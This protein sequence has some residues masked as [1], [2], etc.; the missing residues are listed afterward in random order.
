ME[1]LRTT[2]QWLMPVEKEKISGERYDIYPTHLLP[3]D[4]IFVGYL[5]LARKIS[6]ENVVIIDG[7][8]GV[9]WDVFRQNLN[10]AL[11]SL[12]VRAVWW[13][14][15][16]ALKTEAEI[17]RMAEPFL[18]GD[19][20][21][22]GKKTGLN[23][24]DYFD[25]AGLKK[26][27]P[28]PEAGV[29]ILIG[30]GAALAGWEGCLI[31]IDVPKNEIQFRAKAGQVT[32]LGVAEPMHPKKMY[33]RFYFVD[34]ILL[35][36]HKKALLPRM[37]VVVDGQHLDTISWISGEDLRAGL[38]QLACNGF[39]VRPWFESATWGGQWIKKHIPGLQTDVPNYA[40]SFELIV[41]E[42]GILF[43]SSSQM[44]EVS[45]DT[46]MFEAGEKVVGSDCYQQYGDEFPIRMD[47]LDNMEGGNLSLQCHPK[48]EYARQHFG[49]LMAQEETYYIL[50][51]KDDA[52]VYLGFQD[53][54]RPEE[55]EKALQDSFRHKAVL[56]VDRY[57]KTLPSQKHGLYLIPPGTLHSSGRNN[58]VL[59]ISTTP[60]IFTFKMYDWLVLDLDGK[61]RPL[62]IGRGMENL[63]FDR[64]GQKV[65]QE[66]VS[67]PY[68]SERGQDWELWHLPTHPNHSYD[69]HRL[70]FYREV[71]VFTE[72]KCHVLNLVEG[73]KVSIE[74]E[75]GMYQEIT[76]GETFVIA[77]TAGR[78]RLTNLSGDKVKVV[79]AYM[80]S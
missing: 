45:F 43:E 63:C 7:Y 55:F 77:A 27:C 74:T 47:Y 37:D 44:F 14:V 53:G 19:D 11:C 75:G 18:G 54:I 66:L 71:E 68:L 28:E 48:R 36:K 76:Y 25:A 8:V 24:S 31:Y 60:Y 42:N 69:V 72:G 15:Q 6:I 10:R 2:A 80:K 35:N 12:G 23:L 73:K 33:K 41:P 22:F 16:A 57:V 56:E 39:R 61:P 67:H 32:N 34:W 59:E 30:C 79:K 62:N 58:L 46:L 78:Y 65:E 38:R 3:D 49:E 29:N 9:F 4:Q 5:S 20:P 51:C 70:E 26:L 13:D 50:D 64:C 21:I 40:W 17:N 52:V 1:S